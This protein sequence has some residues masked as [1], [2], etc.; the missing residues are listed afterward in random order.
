MKRLPVNRKSQS[1]VTLVVGLM[2][3]LVITIIAVAVI[4]VVL[5]Q[6][7]MARNLRDQTIAFE[8]AETALRAAETAI[9]ANT[10]SGIPFQYSRFSTA[11]TATVG[12]STY[13]GLCLPSTTSTPQWRR[14]DWSDGSVTT[15]GVDTP[16]PPANVD[17]PRYAIEL[18]SGKPVFLVGKG[19][20]TA[21]FRISARGFGP[22]NAV[23]NIQSVYRYRVPSC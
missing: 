5:M 11:C 6:E 16:A 12:G 18:L 2:I 9:N 8:Y 19:C 3:L 17:S 21:V 22:N 13:Y 23:V 15:V 7:R 20:S 4:Q 14:V 10:I 1:G